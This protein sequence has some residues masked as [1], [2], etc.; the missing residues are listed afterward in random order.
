MKNMS[1]QPKIAIVYDWM[2]KWGGVERVLLTLNE[3]YPQA[4]FYTS[5]IDSKNAFWAKNLNVKT[6]FIQRLPSFIRKN[7]VISLFFYPYAFESFDFSGYDVVISITSSFAKGII[8]KPSTKHICYLLTPTRFLWAYPELYRQNK[9]ISLISAPLS[10]KLKE[11]DYIAAQRPDEYISISK[12]IVDRCRKYYRRESEVVYPPFDMEYWE[13]V[14]SS[15]AC[16]PAGRFGVRR[17]NINAKYFLVVSRLEKYKKVDLV[18]EAFNELHDKSLIVIGKGTQEGKLKRMAGKNIHFISSVTDEELAD[19]YKNAEA[20]IMPQEEDFG[21]VSLE[22]QFFGC[23]VIA[24]RK[25]GAIETILKDRTGIF[26]D[27]QDKESLTTAIERFSSMSYNLKQTVKD[28]SSEHLS[29]FAKKKFIESITK[30]IN[31]SL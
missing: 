27:I 23:P 5:Y 19:Y 25:G 12:T 31:N 11:W 29:K 18:I 10:K 8:T 1:S 13:S 21:Y 17:K 16:L 26:F 14:G 3:I 6:S 7:R 4:D 22:A 28:L 2:D 15:G 30:K 24:F 20:L 9:L